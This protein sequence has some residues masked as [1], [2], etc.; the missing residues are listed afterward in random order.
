M[1]KKILKT[2]SSRMFYL[3]IGL[4]LALGI[5]AAQAAWNSYVGGGQT[6]TAT[7]WNEIVAKLVE[8]DGRPTAKG[9]LQCTTI[10]HSSTTSP[11]ILNCGA[12]YIMTG[13]G[14]TWRSDGNDQYVGSF[15]SGN[16][17]YCYDNDGPIDTC[18]VRCCKIQ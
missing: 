16:G 3:L 7:S 15:P 1:L 17:W 9:T 18:W 13:G 5:F 4:F 2:V 11:I 6:L 8:L 14:A 10:G 12:G